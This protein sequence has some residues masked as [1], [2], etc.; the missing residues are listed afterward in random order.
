MLSHSVFLGVGESHLLVFLSIF[1]FEKLLSWMKCLCLV[2]SISFTKWVSEAHVGKV[3]ILSLYAVHICLLS[4]QRNWQGYDKL[5]VSS[6]RF[7]WPVLQDLSN[8]FWFP[9]LMLFVGHLCILLCKQTNL[10]LGTAMIL[11]WYCHDTLRLM[12]NR[13]KA[14]IDRKE[15]RTTIR[16]TSPAP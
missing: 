5:L 4:S 6:S 9:A 7:S 12:Q 8:G 2:H 3:D 16:N 1:G 15:R 11:L 10:I 13:S 14:R